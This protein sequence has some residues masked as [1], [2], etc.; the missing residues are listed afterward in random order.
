VWW[1]IVCKA[2]TLLSAVLWWYLPER[3]LWPA[4]LYAGAVTSDLGWPHG[5]RVRNWAV[6]AP[7]L[8]LAALP[9]GLLVQSGIFAAAVGTILPGLAE[10]IATIYLI[11]TAKAATDRLVPS[12][13]AR[14]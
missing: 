11:T 4:L 12:S 8:A 3:F 10:L 2:L 14:Q 1:L 9:I 6:A 13:T 7:L 5:S